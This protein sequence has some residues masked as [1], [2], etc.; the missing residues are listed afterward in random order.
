MSVP[1]KLLSNLV[2]CDSFTKKGRTR[3][4]ITTCDTDKESVKPRTKLLK[5]RNIHQR[6]EKSSGKIMDRR[7]HGLFMNEKSAKLL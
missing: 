3:F 2:K 4:R 5:I 6:Q 7:N 1:L